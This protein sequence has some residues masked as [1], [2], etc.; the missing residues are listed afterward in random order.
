MVLRVLVQELHDVQETLDIPVQE[1][2]GHHLSS[3]PG[4]CPPDSADPMFA[5]CL[6]GAVQ[7]GQHAVGCTG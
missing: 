7:S 3:G 4:P 1:G 6:Q 5:L 2:R